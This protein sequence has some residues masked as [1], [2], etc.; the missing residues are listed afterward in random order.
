[1]HGADDQQARRRH[2]G[3]RETA[4]IAGQ[5]SAAPV[6]QTARRGTLG[7][8]V[9]S[10]GK[11]AA[12]ACGIDQAL[13]AVGKPRDH[14]QRLARACASAMRA[15]VAAFIPRLDEHLHATAAGQADLPGLF[16][17]DTEFEQA[18]LAGFA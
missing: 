9:A 14:H 4:R 2:V 18:R 5:G 11:L 12:A 8:C 3:A 17:A 13:R 16:V 10:K 6:W 7:E 1:M 15:S